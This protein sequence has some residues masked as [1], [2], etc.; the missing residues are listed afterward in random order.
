V[1]RQP[2]IYFRVWIRFTV[3]MLRHDKFSY[4]YLWRDGEPTNGNKEYEM[5]ARTYKQS[6]PWVDANLTYITEELSK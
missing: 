4:T 5:R 1:N 6:W 2:N 3:W